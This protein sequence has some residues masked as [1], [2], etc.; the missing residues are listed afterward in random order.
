[1]SQKIAFLGGGNMARSL[2]GGL[3]G[4][5]YPREQITA[6][7]I[8]PETTKALASDFNIQ[9]T[10]DAQSVIADF[11]V[12]VLAVKPQVLPSI[13]SDLQQ[14]LKNSHAILIS[15]AAGINLDTLTKTSGI[16][17]VIRCM[18]NTPALYGV[19][20]TGLYAPPE[21]S[22]T[23]RNLAEKILSS[24]GITAWV[25]SE[26]QLD[27]ITALSG[28][29]PAYGFYFIEAMAAK[30]QS[31]GLP[32]ELSRQFAI[33]TLLGASVMARDTGQAPSDL[34]KAVTSKGGTT[35]AA[36][37]SFEQDQFVEIIAKAMQ[38][39]SDRSAELAKEFGDV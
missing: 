5:Q 31:L 4:Q 8:N 22:Q 29:G 39:A 19:G 11:D 20:A 14:A 21:I 2:I 30:A 27:A 6:I 13:L 34:R 16:N 17:R 7:D 3:I 23:Q 25:D 38:A 37:E 33:Q 26:E 24:A 1:M 12:I 18:P 9:T 28:S 35:A 36:I 10:N 32:L 15:I